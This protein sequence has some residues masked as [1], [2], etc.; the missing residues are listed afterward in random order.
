M[1][2]GVVLVGG[3]TQSESFLDTLFQLKHSDGQW[4]ELP[5]KLKTGRFNHNA[6]LVP[7]EITQCTEN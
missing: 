4:I 5:Q 7:D 3:H 1:T 6:M 2:G